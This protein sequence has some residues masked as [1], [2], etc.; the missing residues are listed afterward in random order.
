[1]G[2]CRTGLRGGGGSRPTADQ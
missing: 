2:D 1:V